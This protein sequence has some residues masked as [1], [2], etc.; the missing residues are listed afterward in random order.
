[1]S[2]GIEDIIKQNKQL[3]MEYQTLVA[4]EGTSHIRARKITKL[5]QS[6]N[7]DLHAFAAVLGDDNRLPR[8]IKYKQR[9]NGQTK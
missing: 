3:M 4:K 5:I 1:M 2:R 6:N 9:M 8:I 7:R